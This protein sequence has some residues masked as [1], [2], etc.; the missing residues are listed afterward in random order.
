MLPYKTLI[1]I[2]RSIDTAV[3]LQIAKCIIKE[4]SNGRISPNTQLPSSRKLSEI[5][6]V[7]RKTIVAAY[8]ELEAQGWVYKKANVGTFVIQNI[9]EIVPIQYES[10][11]KE[12]AEYS[13]LNVN[14][15]FSDIGNY[16]PT[17]DI[18]NAK[19]R[20]DDGFPDSRL[21]PLSSL[22]KEYSSLLKNSRMV[23]SMNYFMEHKGDQFFRQEL[24]N[25]LKESRGIQTTVDNILVTRGSLMAF[26]LL[27]AMTIQKGDK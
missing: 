20:F 22:S 10:E 15:D 26:Y 8:D 27:F 13:F 21:A 2:N 14:Y 11:P 25:H 18:F 7:H 23:K 16:S 24:V 19:Y 9:P 12:S 17:R 6:E 1:P 4:I 3:Y 5:L